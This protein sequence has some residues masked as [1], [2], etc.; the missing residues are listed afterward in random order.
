MEAVD[1]TASTAD[2]GVY[3]RVQ[4]AAALKLIPLPRHG[5]SLGVGSATAA[6]KAN[7][8]S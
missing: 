5:G 7:I 3:R 6:K 1:E 2:L 4:P 8:L